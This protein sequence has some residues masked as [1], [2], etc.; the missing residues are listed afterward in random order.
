[1][2]TKYDG[3]HLNVKLR[4][5]CR[6]IQLFVYYSYN[7][8]GLL[9]FCVHECFQVKFL[10][11]HWDF[12]TEDKIL[13]QEMVSSPF[14]SPYPPYPTGLEILLQKSKRFPRISSRGI[15]SWTGPFHSGNPQF[16]PHFAPY[17]AKEQKRGQAME[18]VDSGQF[19]TLLG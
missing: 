19:E 3:G 4:I 15:V 8:S 10:F 11:A 7:F 5:I 9:K 16:H 1:M 13:F 12:T 18:V 14:L 17:M 6:E 2:D